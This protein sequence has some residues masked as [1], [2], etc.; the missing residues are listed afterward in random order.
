MFH[1]LLGK[2]GKL[3]RKVRYGD[4]A[5]L[6]IELNG[7]RH[8]IHEWMADE[9]HCQSLTFGYDPVSSFDALLALLDLL[10]RE[11]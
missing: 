3:I 4:D 8:T 9:F 11:L 7:V 10:D 1:G 5:F 2:E 6:D